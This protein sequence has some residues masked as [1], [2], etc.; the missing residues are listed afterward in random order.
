MLMLFLESS[1]Q[2]L[3]RSLS[4]SYGSFGLWDLSD[5]GLVRVPEISS[6]AL[7]PQGASRHLEKE[8]IKRERERETV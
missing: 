6:M 4:D 3:H 1:R 7:W 8:T 5:L 2:A